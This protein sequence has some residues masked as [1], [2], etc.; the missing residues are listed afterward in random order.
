MIH[1]MTRRAVFALALS[2]T[3][4]LTGAAQTFADYTADQLEASARLAWVVHF[5]P[6]GRLSVGNDDGNVFAAPGSTWA[7]VIRYG[8]SHGLE[9][10][11]SD[12]TV[13]GEA[14][15][16]AFGFARRGC[17]IQDEASLNQCM[18]VRWELDDESLIDESPYLTL[19]AV[20][21]DNAGNI[22][23]ELIVSDVVAGDVFS[24]ERQ[25][26]SVVNFYRGKAD[27]VTRRFLFSTASPFPSD[28]S[29]APID[30]RGAFDPAT[31]AR[32]L[33]DASELY[34]CCH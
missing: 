4:P 3:A 30:T 25:G 22:T 21:V 1:S 19:K 15:A 9:G 16:R 12:F 10:L 6:A 31:S 24:I 2:L 32:R 29:S 20:I 11:L 28:G 13:G 33:R 7:S 8:G 26:L 5:D 23:R 14:P 27:S 34:F 17:V 18:R